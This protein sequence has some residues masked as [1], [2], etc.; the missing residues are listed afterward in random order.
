MPSERVTGE[1][2]EFRWCNLIFTRDRV[3]DAEPP[4]TVLPAPTVEDMGA[5]DARL[6]CLACAKREP[7]PSGLM[8]TRN[9][10]QSVSVQGVRATVS[11]YS[12]RNA[13]RH[14]GEMHDSRPTAWHMLGARDA[15]VARALE[16]LSCAHCLDAP[17]EKAPMTLAA[18]H[19]HLAGRHDMLAPAVCDEDYY[20]TP[21]A[22]EVYCSAHFPAP[23]LT[24][25]GLPRAGA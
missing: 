12:W 7:P 9:D 18:I 25:E 14:E 15:A 22:P 19:E 10:S 1:F 24:V 16:V 11:A 20:R 6:A 17:H 8:D 21:A 4:A 13:A 23:T 3:F 2:R 5:A